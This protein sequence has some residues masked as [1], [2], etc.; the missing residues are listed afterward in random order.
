V[1]DKTEEPTPKRLRRAKE[2]GDSGQSAFAAQAVAFVVAVSLVPSTARLLSTRSVE[3]LSRA[4]EYAGAA[5]PRATL[6]AVALG[7]EIVALAAPVL[8]GALVAGA[9][10]SVVQTGGFIAVKRLAPRLERLNV[11]DGLKNLL[12][13]SRLFSVAR[14]LGFAAI[15]SYLAYRGLRAHAADL[16]RLGGRI[17]YVGIVAGAIAYGLAKDAA[18]AGLGLA[19]VD[20]VIVRKGWA[21]KLMMSKNEVKQEQKESEG[22]PH[23]KAARERARREMLAAATVANVRTAS[24][25]VVNPTHMA[26][27]L[28]Y[29]EKG[30]DAAPVVV[31]S[32]EGD[33]AQRIMQAADAYGVP[34]LR[35]VPLARALIE[36]EIGDAIPEAL[37]E[38]VAEAL[39]E[40]WEQNRERAPAPHGDEEPA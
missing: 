12:S 20:R 23:F 15:V 28:R 9:A 38:A 34:V 32:G 6:D 24:V 26:C 13:A 40:A 25:V 19:V 27:A 17:P 10:A 5:S 33:V 21:K 4:I 2:E 14:A 36:L 8:L 37:Y 1:S 35:D 18:L 29:D 11:F 30:G 7:T 22:D 16:A 3:G 31:A 39:R